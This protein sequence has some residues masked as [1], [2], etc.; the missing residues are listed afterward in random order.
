MDRLAVDRG[1]DVFRL[2]ASLRRGATLGDVGDDH[3]MVDAQGLERL[4]LGMVLELDTDGPASDTAFFNDVVVDTNHRVD[5][6]RESD[7]FRT[8]RAGRDHCVDANHFATD[9]EERAAAIAGVDRRIGLDEALEGIV[10]AIAALGADD[11]RGYA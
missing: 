6:E 7:A 4:R 11:A 5:G 3:A 2:H 9:V 10:D 8:A 1:D